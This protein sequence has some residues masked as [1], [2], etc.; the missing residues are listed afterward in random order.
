MERILRVRHGGRS[1]PVAGTE[2]YCWRLVDSEK[3]A[4]GGWSGPHLVVVV[5]SV[6]E[7]QPDVV[8]VGPVVA[9]RFLL[10]HKSKRQNRQK[11]INSLDMHQIFKLQ[12]QIKKKSTVEVLICEKARHIYI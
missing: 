4:P 2:E 10:Q 6:S 9:E 3:A 7:L 8:V 11:E 1:A 12:K 5:A